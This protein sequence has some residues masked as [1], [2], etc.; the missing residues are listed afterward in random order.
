MFYT[1]AR[2]QAYVPQARSFDQSLERFLA[3]AFSNGT[4]QST[5]QPPQVSQDEQTV[6]LSIDVPGLTREQIVIT[7]DANIVRLE[8]VKDAPRNLKLAYEIAHDI[9]AD[10]SEAK[11]E[12]GVLTLKLGRKAAVQT[13]KTLSIS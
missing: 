10:S 2:R 13:A 9:D 6:T 8:S 12:N 4:R 3:S 1:P 11:L 7:I 5:A